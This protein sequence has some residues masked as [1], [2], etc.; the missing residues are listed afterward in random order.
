LLA[1]N[2]LGKSIVAAP[3]GRIDSA[4]AG[5]VEAGL[6]A[7]VKDPYDNFVLDFS[8]LDYISSAGLR[9]ILKLGKQV[10]EGGKGFTLASANGSVRE[11]LQMSGFDGLFGL[12]ADAAAAVASFG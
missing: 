9:V 8:N 7:R 4:N 12:H 10:K 3:S 11:I 5:E 1:F 6:F 2:Q